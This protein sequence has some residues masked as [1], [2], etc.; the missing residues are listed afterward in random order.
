MKNAA[1]KARRILPSILLLV[2]FVGLV[3]APAE[4]SN[5]KMSADGQRA[6]DL[7]YGGDPDAAVMVARTMQQ[8]DPQNPVGYLLEGEALWWKRYCGACEVKY[9][10]MEAWT[11][12]KQPADESYFVLTDKAIQLAKEQ[13]AKGE[14]A[15]MHFFVGMGYALKVR[16]YGLRNENRNAARAGVTARAEMMR[17][18][19]LDPELADATGALGLYNY[20]VDTL[21]PVVKLLRFF[22][23][24]PG[25]NKELGVNQMKIGMNQGTMLAVDL[26]FILARALRQYDQKYEE[27]LGI[28]EPLTTR[29]PQNALFLVLAG[30][31]NAELSRNEKASEY[32]RE[33]QEISTGSLCLE[34]THSLADSF[35]TTLGTKHPRE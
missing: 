28:A 35:L 17:A 2:S 15:E 11:H 32:F 3:T 8:A 26:R 34:R 22:M 24:I 18:L 12:D 25:G 23:G 19:E 33:A 4:A 27:A 14:T 13:L 29:Y 21:S 30:N 1:E 20:Y 31:L 10:M 9:G 16:V 5:I 7:L 6:L